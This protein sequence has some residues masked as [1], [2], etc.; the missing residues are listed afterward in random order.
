MKKLAIIGA[1]DLGQLI[2][3]HAVGDNHYEIAGFF[4]DFRAP[5]DL[6]GDYPVLGGVEAILPLFQAGQ[7]DELMIAIGYKHLA[8]RRALFQR[9]AGQ[10]PLG[11][12]V[13]SSASVD[14]SCRLGTGI[15]VLPGCVLDRNVVLADNV[16]LNTACVIAHDSEVGAHTFLSPRVAV[17]G[18]VQIGE[19]CNIGINTT[20][21]DNITIGDG[22]QTG[23]GTVVIKS[24]VQPGLY[25]G[26]PA[27]FVR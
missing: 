22:I 6:A 11:S 13:H 24:L 16:V 8:V 18:F 15:F 5:G 19:G 3:H 4:D 21:I 20:L 2:A 1:G 9:F 23:G 12:V 14:A 25:V 26:N 7:F 27:R 10:V 17:A